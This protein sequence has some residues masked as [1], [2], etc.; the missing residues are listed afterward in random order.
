[1]TITFKR[2]IVLSAPAAIGAAAVLSVA[3]W[4]PPTCMLHCRRKPTTSG[5]VTEQS[6]PSPAPV[7]RRTSTRRSGNAVASQRVGVGEL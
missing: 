2:L 4:P 7:K 1:M 3:A 5:S 6:S